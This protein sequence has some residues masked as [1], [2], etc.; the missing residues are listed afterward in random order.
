MAYPRNAASPPPVAIGA[1]VQISDGAVQTTGVTVYHRTSGT[2][3]T[4]G[5]GTTNVG[6]TTGMVYYTPTQAETNYE[7]FELVAFKTG[8]IPAAVTVV[9]SASATA[10]KSVVSGLDNDAI[11]AAAIAAGAIDAATFAADVDAE[12]AAWIWN[13]ATASYGTAG[14]YGAL[15][16]S[17]N[18]G[19]G[20]IVAAS[21]TGAVGSVTGA[22]GSVTGNVGGNVTG[23]VGSVVG[24]VGSVTGNV[25]GNVTG[26]VGSV[27]TGGIT[28]A[29]IANG[30]IG[31]ATFAADVDAEARGWLGLASA[32]LDTQLAD[33]PT[34]A[35]FEARTLVAA[36]YATS[37][38]LDAV[39]NFV[40][41]EITAL[42]NT[43]GVAGAGLSAIPWNASWDA[44][45]QSECDDAITAST[46]MKRIA[47]GSVGDV[48]G[49]GT[50]TEVFIYGGVTATVTVD[51]SGNRSIAW[52]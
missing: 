33:L 26:S 43:I 19:G 44:E 8:C 46:L 30:A 25:G 48:T 22:V 45:V 41:T 12:A 35:E 32:N 40:D 42:I 36:S 7:S 28:A 23:S 9:T 18:V 20:A 11:T 38:A 29:S 13:A 3:E 6:A 50:G 21:V 15:L 4:S 39:D 24:A 10:G 52:S 49:A 27:A 5:G 37:A 2:T 1:V 34:V 14:T 16:E 31:A 47:V 51:S 17:G